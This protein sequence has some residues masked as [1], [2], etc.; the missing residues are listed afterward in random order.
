MGHIFL[1]YSREDIVIMQRVRDDL[2]AEGLKVWTDEN[3]IP[4]LKSWKRDIQNA[5]D[6]AACLVV[7]LT[8]HAKKSEW[9]SEELNYAESQDVRIFPILAR[10][11]EKTA[12]PFGFITAQRVDIRDESN[13]KSEIQK[14]VFTMRVHFGLQTLISEVP[15]PVPTRLDPKPTTQPRPINVAEK[16]DSTP[17]RFPPDVAKAIVVLQNRESKWWR[18]V[19]AITQL[20]AL[21]DRTVVR[22]LEA[23]LDDKDVDVRRAAERGIQE[24]TGTVLEP[25]SIST[26][27]NV[28]SPTVETSVP[29]APISK[30]ETAKIS[31]VV[32]A[33]TAKS[34]LSNLKLVVTGPTEALRTQFIRSISE[35]EPVTIARE[36]H[37][38]DVPENEESAKVSMTFGRMSLGDDLNIYLFGMPS[39]KQ[40]DFMWK[41]L[42]EGML[43]F[44]FIID[45]TEPQTFG[46]AREIF[47]TFREHANVPYVITADNHDHPDSVQ[48]D[49]IRIILRLD[50]DDRILLCKSTD[51]A[52]VRNTLLQLTYQ[53]L[54]DI[55][56]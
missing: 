33:H 15:P 39:Q 19:D 14:L 9:V 56:L 53:I 11:T 54:D 3:L 2:R 23:Y 48:P 7:V 43:G 35:I 21:R 29:I 26:A 25:T 27:D 28:P 4:G 24:I 44:I 32:Q 8:P 30:E 36:I 55:E 45:S 6:N 10:G 22:V 18:R 49:I 17:I 51:P 41:V 50:A 52:S 38:P 47:E 12:V 1:S 46:A 34:S 40:F 42:G 20:G 37:T 13:Y 5:L 16:R 31:A